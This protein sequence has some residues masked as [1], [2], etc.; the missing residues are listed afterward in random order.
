MHPHSSGSQSAGG[1]YLQRY[2]LPYAGY[3]Q[4][5]G[6]AGRDGKESHIVLYFSRKDLTKARDLLENAASEVP[7]NARA[8]AERQLQHNK[9]SLDAVASYAQGAS[10]CRRVLL[11]RH[12]GE[13]FDAKLCNSAHPI[14]LNGQ[15][16]D[17]LKGL[18]GLSMK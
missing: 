18:C 13:H 5:S 4:E 16:G 17:K 3:H 6:R 9:A 1:V 7:E 14:I 11:M 15:P 12:F 2:V 10:E 8:A